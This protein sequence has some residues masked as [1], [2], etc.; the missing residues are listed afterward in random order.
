M[1]TLAIAD[2]LVMA[3]GGAG[4]LSALRL[5]SATRRER[6]RAA[7]ACGA[8]VGLAVGT[9]YLA[10]LTVAIPIG[11]AAAIFLVTGRRRPFVTSTLLPLTIV[12]AAAGSVFLPWAARNT[13]LTGSPLYPYFDH[14]DAETTRIATNIGGLGLAPD[15]SIAALSIGSMGTK[16]VAERV[17]PQFLWLV[18]LWLLDLHRRRAT[19]DGRRGLMLALGAVVGLI[20]FATVPPLGRFIT[21][22][23]VPLAALGAA[24]W[25]EQISSAPRVLRLVAA[26]GL[27]A[28][29]VGGLNPVRTSFALDQLAVATGIDDSA[30]LLRREVSS[31]SAMETANALLPANSHLLLVAEARTYGFQC[32]ITVQD[33][34]AQPLLVTLSHEVRSGAELLDRLRALGITH[35][36]ISRREME[37][38]GPDHDASR[39]FED[40]D[41]RSRAVLDDALRGL[42]PIWSDTSCQ[43]LAMP[44]GQ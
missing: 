14:S 36:L 21:P 30:D 4:W 31:W 10:A 8:F 18:P 6:T 5:A 26:G 3:F 44:E 19:D 32:D 34:F 7:I 42:E 13:V 25:C 38:L 1:A 9:K 35:V 40:R 24:A 11:V 22:V 17:G 20:G 41:P 16:G 43:L 33:S 15:R 39:Y 27:L 28:V 29:L 37:R 12:V 23:L 2:P